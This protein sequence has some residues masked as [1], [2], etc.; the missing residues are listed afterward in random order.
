MIDFGTQ[1]VVD[2]DAAA[3]IKTFTL[4]IAI[5]RASSAC[6]RLSSKALIK[7]KQRLIFDIMLNID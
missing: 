5:K 2:V 7:G 6:H 1:A 4:L 3:T